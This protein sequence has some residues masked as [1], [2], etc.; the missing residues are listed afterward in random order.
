MTYP[1]PIAST[2]LGYVLSASLSPIREAW[3]AKPLTSRRLGPT[4]V[5]HLISDRSLA[6]A[7]PQPRSP[8]SHCILCHHPLGG[9]LGVIRHPSQMSQN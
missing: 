2:W 9:G 6:R 1:R 8:T 7:E 5:A 3:E 4:P